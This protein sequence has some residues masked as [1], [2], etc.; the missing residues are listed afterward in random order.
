MRRYSFRDKGNTKLGA[1]TRASLTDPE[2]CPDSCPLLSRGCYAKPLRGMLQWGKERLSLAEL[3]A[4]LAALRPGT[5]FRHNVAGDL[6][7]VAEVHTLARAVRKAKLVAWTYTHNRKLSRASLRAAARK[8]GIAVNVSCD[9][10]QD[11]EC[12]AASGPAVAIVDASYGEPGAPVAW[13]TDS[14]ARVVVCPAARQD[15]WPGMTC[16]RCRLCARY[17]RKAIV[18]F[19]AH[20]PLGPA[21]AAR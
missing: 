15:R 11:A 21:R 12:A 20:G 17:D 10:L 2:S 16:E 5:A 18:A 14:G 19:P 7:S 13:R 8:G 9:T 3:C 6:T 1:A 4:K